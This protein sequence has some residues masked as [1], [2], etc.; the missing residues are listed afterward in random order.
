MG[1]GSGTLKYDGSIHWISPPDTTGRVYV[2]HCGGV[3][4][5]DPTTTAVFAAGWRDAGDA[6]AVPANRGLRDPRADRDDN[7]HR[8]PVQRD[9]RS[10]Q[11]DGSDD[12]RALTGY[13][14]LWILA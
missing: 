13:A 5:S 11:R 2:A 3:L 1:T 6:G 10:R 9:L 4:V 14:L 7:L 12:L 8:K